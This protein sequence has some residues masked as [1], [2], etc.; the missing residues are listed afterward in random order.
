MPNTYEKVGPDGE[1]LERSLAFAGT[2]HDIQLSHAATLVDSPWFAVNDA[3]DR[4]KLDPEPV[5]AEPAEEDG[6]EPDQLDQEPLPTSDVGEQH[7]KPDESG[8]DIE[9]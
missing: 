9:E 1:L 7:D 8:D 3:G 4:V 2:V 5:F 6:D